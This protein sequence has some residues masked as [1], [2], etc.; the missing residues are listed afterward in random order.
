MGFFDRF[1]KIKE[2]DSITSVKCEGFF[3]RFKKIKEIDFH[4]AYLWELESLTLDL[5]RGEITEREFGMAKDKAYA[6]QHNPVYQL[7][8]ERAGGIISKKEFQRLMEYWTN[9]YKDYEKKEIK[10][11][12]GYDLFLHPDFKNQ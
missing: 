3:D 9:S 8:R 6:I 11:L 12:F 7:R 2:N 10:R 4:R 1:K 5:E